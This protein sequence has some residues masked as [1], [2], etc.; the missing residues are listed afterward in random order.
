[1]EVT[2]PQE[3]NGLDVYVETYIAVSKAVKSVVP[4]AGFGPSNFASVGSNRNG[5]PD[6]NCA[7]CP[8]ILEFLKR[9]FK[10][11]APLDYLAASDYSHWDK[12]GFAPAQRMADA[13][14]FLSYA[15]RISGFKDTPIEVHEWGWAG[16]GNGKPQ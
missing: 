13:I 14:W 7:A 3:K 15:H 6:K 5:I 9:I 1:M 11:G 10:A 16:W 12:N 4:L 2:L 8:Y